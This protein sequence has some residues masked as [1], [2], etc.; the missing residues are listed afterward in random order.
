[1]HIRTF[2]CSFHAAPSDLYNLNWRLSPLRKPQGD[3]SR[4]LGMRLVSVPMGLQRV[5][6]T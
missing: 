5:L 3:F 6:A 1:M 4:T 2:F